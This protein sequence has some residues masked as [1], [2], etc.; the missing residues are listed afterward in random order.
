MLETV[1]VSWYIQHL[2]ILYILVAV[3]FIS[4]YY[5]FRQ[6]IIL[7][8]LLYPFLT[9]FFSKKKLL[10]WM[11][12]QVWI[13]LVYSLYLA[14][15]GISQNFPHFDMRK[16]AL[17]RYCVSLEPTVVTGP[18]ITIAILKRVTMCLYYH[19][20]TSKILSVPHISHILGFSRILK[21]TK[22]NYCAGH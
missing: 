11:Y 9:F 15:H 4:F 6:V 22:T 18:Y 17:H 16:L 14:R 2:F 12:L 1:V 13:R 21:P 7:S 10:L 8:F 19:V 20:L 3:V 5:Q